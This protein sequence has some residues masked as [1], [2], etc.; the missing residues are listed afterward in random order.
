MKNLV[1][2]T[3]T[4]LLLGVLTLGPVA[5]AQR[6]EQ[7]I[8]ANIPFEFSVGDQVFPAGNYSLVSTPP[9]LL[10]LRDAQGHIVAR[11][12]TNSVETL[13]TPVSPR[14]EFNSEGGR[15]SLAQVWQE[16]HSIGQQLQ[17]SKSWA[18]TAK[19]RSSHT[20]TVAA[21]NSQ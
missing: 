9:A 8:K 12:V 1:A 2:R 10:D 18:K 17:P 14:L 11:V 3:L 15:Y 13:K 16:N 4:S 6:A 5:Q 7:V 21:S 20:Q 19:R